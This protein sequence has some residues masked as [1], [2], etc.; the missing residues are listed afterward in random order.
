MF[1]SAVIKRFCL[2]TEGIFFVGFGEGGTGETAGGEVGDE[3]GG[4]PEED[5]LVGRSWPKPA[6]GVARVSATLISG[7]F[8]GIAA[9]WI[10]VIV[11]EDKKALLFVWDRFL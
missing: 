6:A 11:G 10:G 7:V 5:C 2:S 4:R 1:L 9:V 8:V 3:E